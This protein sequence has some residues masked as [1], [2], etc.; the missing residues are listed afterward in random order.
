MTQVP[1]LFDRLLR[2]L[3]QNLVSAALSFDLI[4][5]TLFSYHENFSILSVELIYFCSKLVFSRI[6][7]FPAIPIVET[8]SAQVN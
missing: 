5:I 8:C 1:A 6:I 4:S 7:K 3:P 2:L